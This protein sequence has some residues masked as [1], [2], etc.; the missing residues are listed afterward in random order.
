[1]NKIDDFKKKKKIEA[2]KKAE[3]DARKNINESVTEN[4][5][6]NSKNPILSQGTLRNPTELKQSK[7][8]KIGLPDLS[9][10][11]KD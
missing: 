7:K 11:P 5:T 9:G 1:M 3:T 6:L 8:K 2:L 10:N 4:K